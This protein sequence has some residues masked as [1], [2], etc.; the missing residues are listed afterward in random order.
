MTPAARIAASIDILD[1]ILVGTPAEKVLTGWGR[2]NRYAGSGDRAAIRDHVFTALRCRNSY[3]YLG[4]AETGRGLMVGLVGAME[5]GHN[6]LFTGDKYAADVLSETEK[7]ARDLSTASRDIQLD[8][9]EW[10]LPRFEDEF[11]DE[12]DAVLRLFQTRA[13]VF[14]RVNTSKCTREEAQNQ[15]VQVDIQTKHHPLSATALEVG[16]NPRRVGQSPAYKDGCVELQDVA[17]QAVVDFLPT[18]AGN[19]VLD[20]CAGGGGKSLALAAQ[21]NISVTAYD[22]EP[23]RMRDI[24][25]RAERAGADI[26]I[27]EKDDLDRGGYDLVLCDAPCSG[28]GSW[29]R[30]PDAKWAL[31]PERLRELVEIQS[32]I[33][34]DARQYVGPNGV[35]AYVTCSVF[36]DE[37]RAQI[38]NFLMGNP[39]W[40][41]LKDRV[42]SPLE[43]GDG[44][45]V[46]LLKRT[47]SD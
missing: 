14:L 1:D 9:P 44:F 35:L 42:F 2:R 33:L 21:S 18:T 43:G 17:S 28:S 3:A 4:R 11:G 26:L 19:R 36:R 15:L 45:F 29:R 20:F 46:A 32:E 23:K 31:T 24:L 40:E 27:A 34:V 38:D 41:L 8:C 22:S 6:V 39:D 30:S 16:E 7:E 12:T 25:L 13:A 10:L 37:N 5:L 47:K